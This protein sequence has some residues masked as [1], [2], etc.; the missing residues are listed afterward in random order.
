[1][2]GKIVGL[3][4]ERLPYKPGHTLVAITIADST[5]HDGRN[6]YQAIDTIAE[7]ART[8]GRTV[9]RVIRQLVRDGWLVP[10][11]KRGSGTN[12]YRFDLDKLYSAPPIGPRGAARAQRRGDRLSPPRGDR[13]SPPRGDRLSP[14]GDRAVS[15]GGDRAVSPG[16]DRA[17]SPNPFLTVINRPSDAHARA[18][19]PQAARASA[20]DP[21]VRR[22]ANAARLAAGLRPV[23]P[24]SELA[25]AAEG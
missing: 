3:L 5:S 6:A 25:R 20:R 15:P 21:E 24:E 2:S 13:L 4:L 7:L 12:C 1:V 19:E 22:L 9:Q 8:S 18:G 17:V 10:D 16:G 14:G 11:G 23:D